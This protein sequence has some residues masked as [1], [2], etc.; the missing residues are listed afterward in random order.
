M[1]LLPLLWLGVLAHY[2]QRRFVLWW[3]L[4]LVLG[5]SWIADSAAH[6]V[7]PW[8]VSA[9]YPSV[10]AM[11]VAIVLL[12]NPA[13]ARFAALIVAATAVPLLW[14]G[15]GHPD[16]VSHTVAWAGLA[17]LCWPHRTL[18]APIAVTFGVGWLGWLAYSIAPGWGTWGAYQSIRALGLGV[19]CWATA[20]QRVRA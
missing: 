7:E 11:I 15:V 12:P 9:V 20:P 13:L 1:A 17:T 6:W 5:V 4:A 3:M 2:G 19:F 16:V 10:Q 14:R 18:R 8:K